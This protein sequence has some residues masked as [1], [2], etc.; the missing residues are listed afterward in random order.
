MSCGSLF[1]YCPCY[2]AV[3]DDDDGGG[4]SGGG[5][6][7]GTVVGLMAMML[8]TMVVEEGRWVFGVLMSVVTMKGCWGADVVIVVSAEL[9]TL[10]R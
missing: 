7:D 2:G 4:G 3:V 6:S 5:G 10:S 8:V 1:A 9:E